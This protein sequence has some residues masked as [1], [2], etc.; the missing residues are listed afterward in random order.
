MV[1]ELRKLR[2]FLPFPTAPDKYALEK[3][4]NHRKPAGERGENARRSEREAPAEN[5]GPAG[6]EQPCLKCAGWCV[7]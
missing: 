4:P 7:L 5:Q 3:W 2:I 6:M 1:S